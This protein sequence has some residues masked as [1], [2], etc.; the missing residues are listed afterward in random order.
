MR[1]FAI[2]LAYRLRRPVL[3][4]AQAVLRRPALKRGAGVVLDRFPQLRAGLRKVMR[5]K[6]TRAA[7]QPS[8][9]QTPDDLSP[10]ALAAY[11]ALQAAF[12]E[13]QR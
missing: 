11:R 5:G 7:R 13:R 4:A 2:G 3:F 10:P 8:V 6:E 1:T 9:P 12:A